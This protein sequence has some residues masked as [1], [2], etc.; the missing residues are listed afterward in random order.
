MNRLIID[1]KIFMKEQGLENVD[2][3]GYHLF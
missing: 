3:D 1:E 2:F